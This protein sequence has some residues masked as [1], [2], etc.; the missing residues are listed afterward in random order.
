MWWIDD[1]AQKA[2]KKWDMSPP[3][4]SE[5]TTRTVGRG[6]GRPSSSTR[7]PTMALNAA[8]M[9]LAEAGASDLTFK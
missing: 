5:C 8:M 6:R 4:R 3:S 7:V 9:R 1:S 2:R